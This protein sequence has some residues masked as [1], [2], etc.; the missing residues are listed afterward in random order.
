M[1]STFA[2]IVG[3]FD[4]WNA[5]AARK[6]DRGQMRMPSLQP[7]LHSNQR[8]KT[9]QNKQKKKTQKRKKTTRLLHRLLAL[10]VIVFIN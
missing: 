3:R 9:Q 8:K 4:G 10:E 5:I 7:L 2:C 6:L 1:G